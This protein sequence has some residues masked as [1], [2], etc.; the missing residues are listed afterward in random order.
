L[1]RDPERNCL[2]PFAV[3][4]VVPL[5]FGA[6]PHSVHGCYDYDPEHLVAYDAAAASDE[7]FAAYLD[8]YVFAPADH[9]AYLEAIGGAARLAEL[10]P[11]SGL[12]YNPQL[13]R[14]AGAPA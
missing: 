12:G 6:H 1:R 10:Q 3:H 14:K 9:A 2:P 4:A 8:R 13:R 5:R 7:S 11:Q